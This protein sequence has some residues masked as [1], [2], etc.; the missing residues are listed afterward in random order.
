MITSSLT[1]L[2]TQIGAVSLKDYEK[3]EHYLLRKMVELLGQEGTERGS[4]YLFLD[5][6]TISEQDVE[7]FCHI[8]E[9]FL[10]ELDE[11]HLYRVFLG[12][13]GGG[14]NR[15]TYLL[16][17]KVSR[18][19]QGNEEYYTLRILYQKF[20]LPV[21]CS[22]FKTHRQLHQQVYKLTQYY[23]AGFLS[24][25]W[26][27]QPGVDCILANLKA[28]PDQKLQVKWAELALLACKDNQEV[29]AST[30]KQLESM[31]VKADPSL[32]LN[33]LQKEESIWVVT[34]RNGRKLKKYP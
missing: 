2:V 20:I 17:K 10:E 26:I 31:G 15:G 13:S 1:R 25:S 6:L 34:L 8:H 23:V 21:W 14:I 18:L 11:E 3:N 32:L 28:V 24:H 30:R 19:L 4:L 9:N 16:L 29:L 5:P 12:L 7:Y 27:D 22:H 33:S